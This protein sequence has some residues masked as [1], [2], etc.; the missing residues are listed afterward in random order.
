MNQIDLKTLFLFRRISSYFLIIYFF[1]N[2]NNKNGSYIIYNNNYFDNSTDSFIIDNLIFNI[3]N[4]I[5]YCSDKFN[6]TKISY[7]IQAF[8]SDNNMITPSE[9][10]LYYNL[11][12]LCFIKNNNSV[13]IFQYNLFS[14]G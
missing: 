11:H 3:I 13:N 6:L 12:I 5:T 1:L 2:S 4:F 8:D 14:D 10:T 7:G 9:L